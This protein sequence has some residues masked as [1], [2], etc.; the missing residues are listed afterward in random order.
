MSSR[1]KCLVH[2]KSSSKNNVDLTKENKKIW[3]TVPYITSVSEKFK[4]IINN[5]IARV[6]FY[7]INKLSSFIKPQK[8]RLSKLSNMNVVY[9]IGCKD[10]DASYVG[11]T[12][13]QLKTRISEHKNHIKR[14]TSTH[15]VITEHRMQRSHE[16]DWENVEILDAERNYSKRLISE[17]INIKCQN[18]SINLQMDTESLDRAYSLVFKWN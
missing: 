5:H 2:D 8:D 4:N 17:M 7:S 18:E 1:I 14:K 16:F 11:Q 13:R 9:R 15:S 3:F 10:C 12:S 6:S